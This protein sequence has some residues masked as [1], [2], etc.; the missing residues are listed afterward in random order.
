ME[1]TSRSQNGLMSLWRQNRRAALGAM[2]LILMAA[3]T[4]CGTSGG[5]GEIPPEANFSF[6]QTGTLTITFTNTSST[7]DTSEWDF[8]NGMMSTDGSPEHTYATPGTYQVHLTVTSA[9]GTDTVVIIVVVSAGDLPIIIFN[10]VPDIGA[11]PAGDQVTLSWTVSGATV[12]TG[13][14]TDNAFDVQKNQLGDLEV[15]TVN[16]DTT[17]QIDCTGPGG[18]SSAQ[19]EIKAVSVTLTASPNPQPAGVPTTLTWVVTNVDTCTASSTDGAFVG[20][21]NANG[22]SELVMAT[23]DTTYTLECTGLG[24]TVSGEVLVIVDIRQP[25]VDLRANPNPLTAGNQTTL[26]WIVTDANSCM[27]SGGSFNG[28]KSP[29]GDSE[30]VVVDRDTTFRLECTGPGGNGFHEVVVAVIVEFTSQSVRAGTNLKQIRF[31]WTLTGTTGINSFTLEVNPDGSS[32]FTQVDLN[33]DGLLDAADRLLPTATTVQITLPLHLTDFNNA[34]YQIV[35]RDGGGA[36]IASS[37]DVFL[38]SIVVEQL[39]G[40]LKASNTDRQDQFGIEVSLSGDGDTLA[41]GAAGEDSSDTGIGGNE[42]DLG[43]SG[44]GA[45]YVFARGSTG[46]WFQQAYIKASNTGAGDQFGASVSLSGDGDTLAVGAFFEDS[47]ATGINDEN[48]GD[49]INSSNSGAVYVFVR[50]SSDVWSQQAYVKARIPDEDDRFGNRV[51]LSGDGDTLA[52]SAIREDGSGANRDEADDSVE[53][54]GAVYVFVRD[55]SDVWSQQAYVKARIPGLDDTFGVTVSLS[56]NGDTL[57]VGAWFEDSSATGISI[58]DAGDDD[59][60]NSGA[61]YVFVRTPGGSW[62]QQAYVKASNT[63][64]HDFF[65]IS[66]SLS[67]DGDTLAV[68]ARGEDSSDTGVGGNEGDFG[69]PGSGA[70]YIFVRDSSGDWSQQNYIKASNT[71]AGDSFG[72]KV[73]LSG[74]GDTLAV[75]ATFEDSSATGIHDEHDGDDIN[76]SNSGAVYVFVRDSSDVWSQQ[77][78]VKASNTQVN[79]LFGFSVSLSGEGDTLAVGAFGEDS[80][81]AGIGDMPDDDSAPDAGAVYLY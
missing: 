37:G 1:S 60:E 53:N 42:G 27:A 71:G 26:S 47:S 24:V 18:S 74:D 56:G 13:S 50:D 43:A 28:A 66:V 17:Y 23:V 75:S 31:D 21:K 36:E 32:G 55:S 63:E 3:L 40:Y 57:A 48:D 7:V 11:V 16:S 35:A 73:S 19:V 68:G 78:Y 65:G 54:S 4:A 22:D 61:A 14:S 49:D 51:S 59:A 79:D 15:V 30:M 67:G 2:G 77:T 52:V 44:S 20:D 76:S 29:T 81:G 9:G 72:L 10:P 58:L 33:G 62:S 6:E 39:I 46:I 34:R 80:I 69:A 64:E 5:E 8:G 70:V 41:V 25:T 45:V 38:T 12:C